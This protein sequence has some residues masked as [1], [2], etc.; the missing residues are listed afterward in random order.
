MIL[1][2]GDRGSR[3]GTWMEKS[4]RLQKYR[5]GARFR[6]VRSLCLFALSMLSAVALGATYEVGP[7]KQIKNP[8]GNCREAEARRPDDH[9]WRGDL[10]RR[11]DARRQRATGPWRDHHHRHPDQRDPPGALGRRPQGC[12]G[13]PDPRQPLRHPGTRSHCGRRSPCLPLLLQRGRRCHPA[14]LRGPRLPLHRH[15]HRRYRRITDPR[16]RGGLPLRQWT[17]RAPDLCR[18]R[19]GLLSP[20]PLQDAKLLR[21][22]CLGR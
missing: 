7:S 21:S 1:G 17:L 19:G 12:G 15:H 22:R 11:R 20:G 2:G 5:P 13:P 6:P 16:S 9:R 10:S 18:L 8:P 14:R 4:I 3:A